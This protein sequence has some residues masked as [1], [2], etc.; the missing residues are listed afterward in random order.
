MTPASSVLSIRNIAVTRLTEQPA[1]HGEQPVLREG[2]QGKCWRED[3]NMVSYFPMITSG[4]NICWA[5]HG[6]G[7]SKGAKLMGC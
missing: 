4:K 7:C 5:A 3:Q 6:A 2:G 1:E